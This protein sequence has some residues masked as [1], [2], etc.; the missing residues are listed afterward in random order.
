MKQTKLESLS[1]VLLVVLCSCGQISGSANQAAQG[2]VA[3]STPVIGNTTVTTS[4]NGTQITPVTQATPTP[5]PSVTPTPGA[6]ITP[7][8]TP[9]PS[10]TPAALD[11]DTCAVVAANEL[12]ITQVS[13]VEDAVRSTWSGGTTNPQDGAW[14]LGR[15]LTRLS[16]SQ[17]AGP[18]VNS[19]LDSLT[20]DDSF[21]A[22]NW[23]QAGGAFTLT[24]TPLLLDAIVN[25]M[26]LR[27]PAAS[28]MGELRFVFGTNVAG[29]NLDGKI[30]VEI[31]VA[32]ST[33]FSAL[34]WAQAW[35][36]L[37]DPNLTSAQFNAQLQ[38]LTDYALDNAQSHYRIRTANETPLQDWT[39]RQFEPQSGVLVP[40]NLSLTPAARFDL[41]S[42]DDPNSFF[43]PAS[44]IQPAQIIDPNDR[45]T[46]LNFVASISSGVG[47]GNYSI[48]ASMGAPSFQMQKF[49]RFEQNFVGSDESW[50]I[51]S[52]SPLTSATFSVNTCNGCHGLALAIGPSPAQ[53][54]HRVPG[55]PSP[56]ADFLTGTSDG[57][58]NDLQ[59]RANDLSNILCGNG[60]TQAGVPVVIPNN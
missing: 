44:K 32:P 25:R 33:Q 48:P 5:T 54:G 56:L 13:V 21:I 47:T 43:G 22:G 2:S 52:V 27:D 46:L 45:A 19:L 37:S 55:L 8:P 49:Y 60:A 1:I 40:A 26:D 57:K 15:I 20:D 11:P 17:N 58:Y 31:V 28:S 34:T 7:T 16:A 9:T 36:R 53:V 29:Q 30:I 3:S 41:L 24:G 14:A 4:G 59:R 50:S 6:S 10:A 39:F 12:M 35:H 18:Y 38:V 23:P 51:T 42:L